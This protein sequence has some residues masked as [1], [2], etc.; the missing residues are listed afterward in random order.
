MKKIIIS[1][2]LGAALLLAA[3]APSPAQHAGHG[4]P[5]A[6]TMDAAMAGQEM[7]HR[8]L[9]APLGG[10]WHLMGMA[11]AVPIGTWA[12][13]FDGSSPLNDEEFYL[14]QP[15]IMANLESPGSR[16]VLRTT[17]NFEGVTLDEGEYTF[18]AW[19]EGFIDKR[20]PHTLLHELMLSFNLWDAPGGA[21]SI[22]AGK[23]FA[24]YG[25]DDPMAR[26]VLKY[27]TNHHL[28]QMLE[29]WTLS[30]AYL[31]D[32]GFSVEAGLFG[33]EEPEGPYDLSNIESFGDSWS[34][35]AAQRF[36]DGFGPLAPWE[37]SA[38]YAR[39]EHG[40]GEPTTY[41][42]NGA[43]RHDRQYGFGRLY[44]LA[45]ASRSEI[46]GPAEGY[47]SILGE[48][49][50]ELGPDGRHQPYY[51]IE[52]ATRP[53]YHREGALGTDEFFRYDH[54]HGGDEGATRWLINSVGYGYELTDYPLSVRPFAEVQHNQVWA[55]R[56]GVD[57]EALFGGDSFWS[58]SA[59]FRVFLGGDP[60]RMG[61]YGVLDS[62]SAA[63]RLVA[64]GDGMHDGHDMNEM[65]DHSDH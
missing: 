45:E 56:G 11:Q 30:G 53:E 14:T 48:T 31:T 15:A 16:L 13:P 35:R 4:R 61:S 58:L 1:V 63:M 46:E 8:M 34:V 51:R 60:M 37:V 17:L 38:S 54:A 20:H 32:G 3:P 33:G 49:L 29:R 42:M 36:G 18:G 25:T 22:S 44:A 64:D 2:A 50:A 62:M 27:P 43:I 28:S 39:V 47:Y 52:Y 5:A 10:G 7:P 21:F 9:M 26:P 24:P 57:P 41:L 23:G 19:G 59:G 6:D 40:H 12:T 65:S 55:E